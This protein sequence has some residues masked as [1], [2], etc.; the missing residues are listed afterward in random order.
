MQNPNSIS[1]AELQISGVWAAAV[2]PRRDSGHQIDIASTLDLLDFLAETGVDGLSILG[3]TGEFVH[4]DMDERLHLMKFAMKRTPKRV[5]PCVTHSTI[6]GTIALA[7]AAMG[8]GAP[9]VLALPPYYFRYGA[10]EVKRFYLT[11]LDSLAPGT[12]I[13]L[14]NI[15]FFS[16][17][18][19]I[20]LACELLATGAFAGIKDSSGDKE[21]CRRLLE[22]K[23]TQPFTLIIGNDALY[24]EGRRA[25]AD[26]VVS[27]VAGAFPELMTSLEAAVRSGDDTRISHWQARLAESLDWLDRYPVPMALRRAAFLRGFKTSQM[28]MPMNGAFTDFDRWFPGFLEKVQDESVV[29]S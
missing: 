13:F 22:V 16:S 27:G 12:P 18:L 21:Y 26:A 3:S 14:Y 1:P 15:P 6:D 29:R 19:P 2:T 9:A 24:V 8:Y 11:L 20:N 17:P 5:L 10:E 7:E 25:G 28:A 4:F 23:K